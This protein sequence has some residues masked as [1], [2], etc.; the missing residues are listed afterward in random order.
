MHLGQTASF[1]ALVLNR[2]EPTTRMLS[3]LL[4]EGE[5]IKKGSRGRNAPHIDGPELS[6]F[7]IAF[8]CCPDSPAVAMERLPHFASLPLDSETGT[9]ATFAKGLALLLERLAKETW[10]E[11]QGKKWSVS[12]Y[13]DMSAATISADPSEESEIAPEE[14]VFSAL[15]EAPDDQPIKD[16]LPYFGGLETSS[17]IR[18]FTLFRI[19]KVILAGEPDPLDEIKKS[20]EDDA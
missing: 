6:S 12:L 14:H 4:R 13:V 2:P 5:W 3:R 1:L 8:M 15:V 16:A 20:L 11:A 10:E 17:K 9:K 19:A 7:L 18:D